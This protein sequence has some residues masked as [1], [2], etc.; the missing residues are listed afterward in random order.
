MSPWDYG[1][2]SARA[3]P[4]PLGPRSIFSSFTSLRAPR[5]SPLWQPPNPAMSWSAFPPSSPSPPNSS[6]PAPR[7]LSSPLPISASHDL[8]YGVR[9]FCTRFY[10]LIPI[11]QFA[12]PPSPAQT[13]YLT[14]G[15]PLTPNH[16]QVLC[17]SG[18]SCAKMG[19]TSAQPP[20]PATPGF[21]RRSPV[22]DALVLFHYSHLELRS[23]PGFAVIRITLRGVRYERTM[24]KVGRPGDR[25]Q[26]RPWAMPFQHGIPGR[27]SD[28]SPG[29]PGP[30]SG[31]EIGRRR[32]ARYRT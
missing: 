22:P 13:T 11:A 5:S 1:A 32:F 9:E 19:A 10:G 26:I 30:K 21:F 2:P 3:T 18:P 27:I 29:S 31:A 28:E 24:E 15:L 23:P 16:Q 6:S 12:S 14:T 20:A 17:C 8:F 4:P 7:K 25:G